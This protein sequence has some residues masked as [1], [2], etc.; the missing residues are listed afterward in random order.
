MKKAEI[1]YFTLTDEML[2]EDKLAWFENTQFKHIEFDKVL[3]DEKGNWLNL[4]DN[5]FESLMPVCDKEVKLNKSQNAIFKL[6]SLGVVTSRD[7]WVYDFNKIDLTK[8][9]NLFMNVYNAEIKR[10]EKSSK[11][12]DINDF[13]DRTIKWT[14]ELEAH[15]KKGNSLTFDKNCIIESLYRPFIKQFFYFDKIITHRIYQNEHIFGFQNKYKNTLITVMG[16]ST[17][18]PFFV[19]SI[20]LLPDL[21]FVSPASGGTQCLPLYVYDKDGN[22]HDNITDWALN[23]FKS[24]YETDLTKLDIFHYVYAVLHNPAYREKYELNLKREF[25][26]IPFYNNFFQ[27]ADWGKQL[28]DLH[29]NY[30]TI[31]KYPL[32][33]I[34]L[35]SA[36]IPKAKLKADKEN[37]VIILDDNTHLSEI[38]AIAWDYKLGNRSALEWVLDQ[39]KEKK[40][41][42]PTIAEKFNHYRFADYKEHV[43]DLLMRVCN[44]SVETMKIIHQFILT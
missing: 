35:E 36:K 3:P 37:G 29:L 2:R 23:E 38:P 11:K 30:E 4:T 40:P 33:R 9:V 6:F 8:K 7:D 17:G 32:K 43:I 44:V 26:H 34:D 41:K 21:N 27:W 13:V 31:E 25:P 22:R 39:Y 24:H 15:L 10:W 19:L 12:I 18:K 5:D 1:Y 16:D 42:D 14:E 28:M 20:N